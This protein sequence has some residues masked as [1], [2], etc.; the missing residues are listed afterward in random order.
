MVRP[1][2]PLSR[3][4][5]SLTASPISSQDSPSSRTASLPTPG[6]PT[7]PLADS[8]MDASVGYV[9]RG[10]IPLVD[11]TFPTATTPLLTNGT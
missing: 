3:Q 1:L 7:V 10:P 11:L 4:P 5:S 6:V 8:A 2:L 9:L